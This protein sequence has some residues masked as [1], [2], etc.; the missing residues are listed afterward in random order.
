VKVTNEEE[1]GEAAPTK[2]RGASEARS[3]PER[4]EG[5]RANGEGCDR[6]K[7][8]NEVLAKFCGIRNAQK[9]ERSTVETVDL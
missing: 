5:I 9:E 8:R 7:T 6:G 1:R 2:F 3:V 4:S